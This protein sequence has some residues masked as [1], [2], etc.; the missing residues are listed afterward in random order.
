MSKVKSKEGKSATA[1]AAPNDGWT[2]AET[3]AHA[4][5][6]G[7]SEAIIAAGISPQACLHRDKA[8][9]DAV[10]SHVSNELKKLPASQVAEIAAGLLTSKC[11]NLLQKAAIATVVGSIANELGVDS[12]NVEVVHVRG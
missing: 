11:R 7:A 9:H 8:S 6:E 2:P 10:A 3:A 1:K 12:S 5:V 4:I